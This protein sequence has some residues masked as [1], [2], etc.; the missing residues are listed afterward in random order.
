[1]SNKRWPV[2]DIVSASATGAFVVVVLVLVILGTMD[3]CGII[4]G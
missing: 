1:M 2:G 4:G 3:C